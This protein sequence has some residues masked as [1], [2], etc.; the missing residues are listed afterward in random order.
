MANTLETPPK[1]SISAVNIGL[2]FVCLFFNPVTSETAW[3]AVLAQ[4][5]PVYTLMTVLHARLCPRE[6]D[7]IISIPAQPSH[8]SLTCFFPSWNTNTVAD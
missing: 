1:Q 6:S 7:A 8:F 4:K 2:V 3:L 5:K